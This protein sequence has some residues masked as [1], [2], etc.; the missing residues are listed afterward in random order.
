MDIVVDTVSM[1]HICRGSNKGHD[2]VSTGVSNRKL[3]V[4]IDRARSLVDEWK[5]TANPEVVKNLLIRWSDQGGVVAVHERK[6]PRGLATLLAKHGFVD[7]CDKLAV[8]IAT[9]TTDR[10]II[11]EDSDFWD[12]R[13]S[14]RKGDRN[15]PVAKALWDEE[16]IVPLTLGELKKQI[17]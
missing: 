4:A 15:A 12:P 8:R 14:N 10:I 11:T 6:M 9:A 5:Q 3:R 2:V 16:S 7:T 17:K 1:Q 13:D